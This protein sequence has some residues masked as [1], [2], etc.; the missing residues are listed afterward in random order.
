MKRTVTGGVV[1]A[2]IAAVCVVT[3]QGQAGLRVPRGL[4]DL[5]TATPGTF[6]DR[7]VD[8]GI[9]AGIELPERDMPRSF[10]A[11]LTLDPAVTMPAAELAALFNERHPDYR[12]DVQDGVFVIRPASGRAAYLD[13]PAPAPRM[14]VRGL[15]A[16]TRRLFG[17]LD[18]KLETPAGKASPPIGGV[19]ESGETIVLD[20]APAGKPVLRVLNEIVSHAPHRAWLA[21]TADSMPPRVS[22]IGYIRPNGFSL[23]SLSLPKLTRH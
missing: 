13:Q 4:V 7:L 3:I 12:A 10:P 22:Q 21:L 9:P 5:V 19:D 20:L 1:V 17:P 18:P 11:P 2:L 16:A 15:M 23:L 8:A 14:Q 6:T